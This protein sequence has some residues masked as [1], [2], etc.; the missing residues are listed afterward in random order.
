M[1]FAILGMGTAVPPAAIT[2]EEGLGIARVLGGPTARNSGFLA[3]V[4]TG[5]GNRQRFQ[6]IGR[7]VVRDVLEGTRDSGSVFLPSGEP[8]YLGPTTAQRM[9]VYAE[10]APK[11]AIASARKALADSK[12]AA[13]SITHLVTVTCTGF[14]APGLDF[15]IIEG[16]PLR[17]T[18]ERTQVG[19]MGCQGALNGLRVA[20]ALTRIPGARVLLC[21]TELCSIHYH[22]GDDPEKVVANALFADG[23]ASVVGMASDDDSHWHVAATGSCLIPNSADAMGWKI[24]D[25]GF[26]MTLARRLPGIIAANLRPWMT[27]WLAENDLTL[28]SVASWAV[29]PGGPK[30]L[31]AVVEGLDLPGEAVAISREVFAEHGNMSSP[32]VLFILERLRHRQAP[33]PCVA[34]G[35]GPGLVAEAVLLR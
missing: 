3:A 33:R 24:A 8:A 32:T 25:H 28:E 7:D 23:S 1:S 6:V 21:A 29:H 16:L 26:E 17:P 18:V 20:D 34:L 10:E 2:A 27:E 30:I 13:D 35:F 15:A 5:T 22:Y 11:L 9:S 14:I 31:D 12:W 4:Y 19:F